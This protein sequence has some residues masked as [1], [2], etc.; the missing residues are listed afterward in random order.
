METTK[1]TKVIDKLKNAERQLTQL[2]RAR[3]SPES[4]WASDRPRQGFE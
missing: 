3:V 1:L 2:S 4:A